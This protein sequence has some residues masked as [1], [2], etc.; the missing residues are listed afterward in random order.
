[1]SQAQPPSTIARG[2]PMA[3]DFS[4]VEEELWGLR[5]R[6]VMHRL[7]VPEREIY[8]VLED[9]DGLIVGL[10]SAASGR[11]DPWL[12]ERLVAYETELEATVKALLHDVSAK[13]Y[14]SAARDVLRLIR[15]VQLLRRESELYRVVLKS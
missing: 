4:K 5:A 6:L 1:M 9:V 13:M 10:V 11:T 15:I 3:P 2:S 7:V 12:R 8:K 14:H